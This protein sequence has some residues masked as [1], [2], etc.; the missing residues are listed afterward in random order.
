MEEGS[1]ECHFKIYNFPW[2]TLPMLKSE[3]MEESQK[4]NPVSIPGG[5]E[6]CP[7]KLKTPLSAP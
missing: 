1:S 5:E 7:K 4:E 6:H 2:L 3:T